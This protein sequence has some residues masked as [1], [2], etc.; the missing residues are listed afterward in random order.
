MLLFWVM[1]RFQQ[2]LTL[3]ELFFLQPEWEANPFVSQLI[4]ACAALSC[5]AQWEYPHQVRSFTQAIVKY[6]GQLEWNLLQQTYVDTEP[7]LGY[8]RSGGNPLCKKKKKEKKEKKWLQLASIIGVCALH[9]SLWPLR[10][11]LLPF[12]AALHWCLKEVSDA[13][14]NEQVDAIDMQIARPFVKSP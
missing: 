3:C 13:H 6:S 5:C 7:Y 2:H 1:I 4:S 8:I 12:A 9:G 14:V 11:R 10:D